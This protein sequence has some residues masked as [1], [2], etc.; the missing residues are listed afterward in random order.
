MKVSFDGRKAKCCSGD[1]HAPVRARPRT[2]AT[3]A[4][5]RLGQRQCA[6]ALHAMPRAGAPCPRPPA[7][8]C[9]PS[10]TTRRPAHPHNRNNSHL[11]CKIR[12]PQATARAPQPAAA[13]T[14]RPFDVS[15]LPGLTSFAPA[16]ATWVASPPPRRPCSPRG[17]RARARAPRPYLPTPP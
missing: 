13:S 1:G 5:W 14:H 7:T 9:C 3:Q 12:Y 6:G 10:Q 8:G 17:D 4:L 11:Q 2:I 15:G 16:F